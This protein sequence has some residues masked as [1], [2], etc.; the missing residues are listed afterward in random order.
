MQ[1]AYGGGCLITEKYRY[2][3]SGCERYESPIEDKYYNIIRADSITWDLH[4]SFVVPQ[5]CSAILL[6]HKVS[7]TSWL[8]IHLL[9]LGIISREQFYQS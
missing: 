6:K 1:A 3:M 2:L 9:F 5:Q 8:M 7:L 4:K